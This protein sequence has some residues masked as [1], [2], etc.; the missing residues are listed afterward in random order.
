MKVTELNIYPIKSTR[1]VKL[2]KTTVLPTG[3]THDREWLLIDQNRELI[4]A[5]TYPRLLQVESI[6][7]NG[8]LKIT[9]PLESFTFKPEKDGEPRTFKFFNEQLGGKSYTEEANQW[10][11]NYLGTPCQLI[12]QS[13]VY[14]PMLEK[15]GGQAG[16][17]VNFGDEGPVLMIGEGSLED[18]NKRLDHPVTMGHFRPNI[19][20]RGTAPYE[21]DN[22]KLIR[23]G[24]CE[25]EVAQVCRRCVFTTIDP[26]TQEKN[27]KGE[28]LRTLSGYRKV[29]DGG[30]AFGVHLI[31]RKP[32]ELRVGEEVTFV[33]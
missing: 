23:I 5:R 6:V 32:G 7:E 8:K 28:P 9:T 33:S 26:L 20:I 21:E 12:H 14:R 24:D 16:D 3:L 22:W 4:T 25:F 29:P 2:E 31:P 1:Q 27:K 15:R 19:V 13:D 30:V 17:Q 18:L 10:F 11:S